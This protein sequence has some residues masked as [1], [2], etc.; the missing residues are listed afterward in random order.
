MRLG[1][2]AGLTQEERELHS[3]S[4]EGDGGLLVPFTLSIRRR[5]KSQRKGWK[6][7]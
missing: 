6:R 3:R 7:S 5:R 1:E 4:R 2:K